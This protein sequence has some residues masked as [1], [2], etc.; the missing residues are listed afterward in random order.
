MCIYKPYYFCAIAKPSGFSIYKIT[1]FTSLTGKTN[2]LTTYQH[3]SQLLIVFSITKCL[4]KFFNDVGVCD[5]QTIKEKCVLLIFT[6]QCSKYFGVFFIQQLQGV[7]H[8]ANNIVVK[9]IRQKTIV[10][11]Y[12]FSRCC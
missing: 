11:I 3:G 7:H 4:T 2:C 9:I 10:V 8:L 5:Y 12:H 1:V 6:V